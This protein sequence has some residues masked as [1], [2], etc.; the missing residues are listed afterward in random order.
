MPGLKYIIELGAELAPSAT[1]AFGGVTA[2]I[3]QT[4]ASIKALN[5]EQRE[6]TRRMRG[7]AQGTDEYRALERQL[8]DVEGRS[9][10]L[11]QTL[12]VQ[13]RRLRTVNRVSRASG[14]IFAA[15]TAALGAF[16]AAVVLTTNRVGQ[17]SREL[18]TANRTTGLSVEYLQTLQ[19]QA[20]ATGRDLDFQGPG[21]GGHTVRGSRRRGNGAGVRGLGP[22]GLRRPYRG[23]HRHSRRDRGHP[24][25]GDRRRPAL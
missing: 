18:L 25:A 16:A 21:R 7:V 24:A 17:Y 4:K 23:H 13:E 11:N 19:R 3:D 2:E 15:N 14:R 12:H 22:P 9:A 20:Q 5:V 8:A 1:A 6:F 10:R